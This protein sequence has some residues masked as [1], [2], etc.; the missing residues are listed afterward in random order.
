LSSLKEFRENARKKASS[1][2]VITLRSSQRRVGHSSRPP[3]FVTICS[4]SVKNRL[5]YLVKNT[6]SHNNFLAKSTMLY[7]KVLAKSTIFG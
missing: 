6:T 1:L 5:Y 3:I 4:V 2:G 7:K